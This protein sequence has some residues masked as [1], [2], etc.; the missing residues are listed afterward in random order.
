M[1]LLK[2][3]NRKLIK[4]YTGRADQTFLAT[5]IWPLAES[6]ILIHDSFHCNY[7]FGYKTEPYPTQRP[8]A[9]EINCFL[10]CLRP[11]CGQ[12]KMSFEE[13]PKECRPKNHPEW[14]YC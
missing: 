10:G 12:G 6:N 13:C 14:I 3:Y 8:S 7:G 9:N 4:T 1:I 11:C 2:I 5:H